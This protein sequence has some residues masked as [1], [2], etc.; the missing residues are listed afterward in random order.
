M[1]IQSV[2]YNKHGGLD[3]DVRPYSES[4][5]DFYK[6]PLQG[7]K[8]EPL[9]VFDEAIRKLDGLAVRMCEL[10]S[11]LV[12]QFRVRGLYLSYLKEGHKSLRMKVSRRMDVGEPH[13]FDTPTR[14]ITCENEEKDFLSIEEA[15]MVERVLDLA[16]DYY[17]GDRKSLDR[18]IQEK[19]E[20]TR[21][22]F[23]QGKAAFGKGEAIMDNPFRRENDDDP[24]RIESWNN[25]WLE[26]Q[27]EAAE[28]KADLENS[29]DEDGED[30][31]Q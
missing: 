15:E 20:E 6:Q 19:N 22:A 24:D 5:K 17:Y 30:K 9:D 11:T 14:P 13:V 27:K 21:T 4:Q 2:N 7:L 23:A 26:A 29:E 8:E 18:P 25:G 28:L 31:V 3:V 12:D 10:P 1:R 16:Q